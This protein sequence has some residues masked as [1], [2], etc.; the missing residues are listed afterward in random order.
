MI[1]NEL[2]L[3]LFC[4]HY[5]VAYLGSRKGEAKGGG[6]RGRPKGEAKGGGQRGRSKGDA[7]GG[8]QRGRPK[9]AKL[10]HPLAF[11][12]LAQHITHEYEKK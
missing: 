6:Q 11:Y 5:S 3:S 4:I 12:V 7:K 10:N 9:G 8:G 1:D 2:K